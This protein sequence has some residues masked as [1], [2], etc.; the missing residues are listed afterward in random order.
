[1][2]QATLIVPFLLLSNLLFA[3]PTTAKVGTGNMGNRNGCYAGMGV[4]V[5]RKKYDLQGR[6]LLNNPFADSVASS[7][8]RVV[9]AITVNERGNVIAVSGAARGSTNMDSVL[10]QKAQIAAYKAQ[11]SASDTLPRQLGTMR[12]TYFKN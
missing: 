9:V 4:G 8:G 11:F 6:T 1:M 10:V 3:Q 5:G 7:A 12:F 2:N